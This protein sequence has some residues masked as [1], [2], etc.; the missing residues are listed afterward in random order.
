MTSMNMLNIMLN[1]ILCNRFIGI[2]KP[3]E[4]FLFAVSL[5]LC[6]ETN[7][8]AVTVVGHHKLQK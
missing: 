2:N 1:K 8:F 3:V 6:C 7:P 4:G 5:F